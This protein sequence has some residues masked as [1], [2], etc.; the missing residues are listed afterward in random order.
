M[1]V[2]PALRLQ[3]VYDKMVI[4]FLSSYL[5][6][7]LTLFVDLVNIFAKIL[8][9]GYRIL[10]SLPESLQHDVSNPYRPSRDE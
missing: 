2:P 5:A 10:H 9:D 6:V 4:E 1:K 8:V 3:L 7:Y